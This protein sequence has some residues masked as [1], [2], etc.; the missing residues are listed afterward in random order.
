VPRASFFQIRHQRS[1]AFPRMLIIAHEDVLVF[2]DQA[3]ASR[4]AT[5]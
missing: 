4:R 3:T 2:G 5:R 1:G